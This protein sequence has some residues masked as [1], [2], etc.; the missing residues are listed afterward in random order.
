MKAK[1]LRL[2]NAILLVAARGKKCLAPG[3]GKSPEKYFRVLYH[4]LAAR[5]G[6]Q[7]IK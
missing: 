4:R 7:G 1:Y 2:A 3:D 5:R 6:R